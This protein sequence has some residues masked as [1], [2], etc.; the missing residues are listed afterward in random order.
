MIYWIP[1]YICLLI[2]SIKIRIYVK[3]NKIESL[4]TTHPVTY[5]IGKLTD[6]Q[7]LG[8]V[9]V[10]AVTVFC[11]IFTFFVFPIFNMIKHNT[12]PDE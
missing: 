11:G 5:K 9:L 12:L 3:K 1:I 10:Y 8:E 6:F 4:D 7:K 2:W